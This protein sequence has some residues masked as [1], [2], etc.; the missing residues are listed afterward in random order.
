MRYSPP[1]GTADE[2]VAPDGTQRPHYAGLLVALGGRG[3]QE[4]SAGLS[5][6]ADR[7]Q[8]L[9]G[10]HILAFDP[11]PRLLGA[12]EWATLA[13]G[14]EQ[15]TRALEAYVT[16]C[17]GAR[18][19][20]AA[21]VVP[22]DVLDTCIYSEGDL[23]G[24][25]PPPRW[26]AVAGPDVIRHPDGDLVVLEDNVRTPTLMAYAAWAREALAPLLPELP[27]PLPFAA[28]LVARL[29]AELLAAT[30]VANRS[31]WCSTTAR[32]TCSAGRLGGWPTRSARCVP[33]SPTC[34]GRAIASSSTAGR[35]MSSTAGPRKSSCAGT[36]E[37]ST[38]SGRRCCLR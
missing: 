29:H 20:V 34:A 31:W 23:V 1:R 32:T 25:D 35:S 38:R 17:Y 2:A 3:L 4:L 11:V 7:A 8:V 5:S 12:A 36:T 18:R 26:I 21:G 37:R 13:A 33:A 15:R 19:A 30:E 16:D 6:A 28:P 9:H 10:D 27:A 14:L 22:A 24:V